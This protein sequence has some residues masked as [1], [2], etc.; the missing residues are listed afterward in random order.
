LVFLLVFH[1]AP[2]LLLVSR[3]K[4]FGDRCRKG[5]IDLHVF[6]GEISGWRG[7]RAVLKFAGGGANVVDCD[8]RAGGEKAAKDGE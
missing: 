8:E 1:V 5:R 6:Y 3:G 2:F 4:D 7:V